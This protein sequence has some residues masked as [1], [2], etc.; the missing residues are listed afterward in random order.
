MLLRRKAKKKVNFGS[1][2]YFRKRGEA[3]IFHEK[4]PILV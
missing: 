4:I 2:F 1:L 3:L